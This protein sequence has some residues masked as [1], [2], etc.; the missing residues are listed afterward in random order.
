MKLSNNFTLEELIISQTALRNNID[1]IP[2]EEET[3]N[4]KQLCINIL[5]PLRDDY[6]LPLVISSGFR[7]KELSSLVGSKPTSQHCSG[8]A[9]DFTIPGV[10]N[11]KVFKHIIENLP[12]DQAILEYY[13]EE[14][15]GWIHIS[16]IPN[17]RGQALTKDKKEYKDYK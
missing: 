13:T 15:G 8:S 9:A 10:D 4:L 6:Q 7:S 5:Q 14:N 1:N 11:K 12:F 2:N 3:E 16:Y 17:G